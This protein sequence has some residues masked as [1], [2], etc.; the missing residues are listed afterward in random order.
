MSK[1]ANT[2]LHILRKSFELIYTRGYNSTSIDD[3]LA[4]T[5]VTKGAFYYHFSSKDE[6]GLAII[7]ELMKPMVTESFVGRLRNAPDPLKAV[8]D[9]MHY[10]L[11]EDP[12][13]DPQYG[14][15][16]GNL[17]QETSAWNKAFNKALR[18]LIAKWQHTLEE[19]L[20]QG[21]KSGVVRRNVQVRQVAYFVMSGYWGIRNFGK[22]EGGKAVYRLHLRELKNYLESLRLT[23]LKHTN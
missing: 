7:N 17:V 1:A 10:L 18:E 15:P 22:L 5:D 16:A 21:K 3:I 23:K 4:T 8:Y 6:M 14:C 9:T 13:L 19:A 11:M 12:F 2:R 20:R